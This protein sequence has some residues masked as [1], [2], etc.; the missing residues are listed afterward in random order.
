MEARPAARR[1]NYAYRHNLR[2]RMPVCGPKRVYLECLYLD[3]Q[4]RR[5]GLLVASGVNGTKKPPHSGRFF[6]YVGPWAAPWAAFR[7]WAGIRKAPGKLVP[8]AVWFIL[9]C[10]QIPAFL[11]PLFPA[12]SRIFQARR[13]NGVINMIL[14]FP[15][16]PACLLWSEWLRKIARRRFRISCCPLRLSQ[17]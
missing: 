15:G 2:L 10:S 6:L 12:Y 13:R 16:F 8:G 5:S 17:K 9:S 1:V 7:I 3:T 11:P 4:K 14:N